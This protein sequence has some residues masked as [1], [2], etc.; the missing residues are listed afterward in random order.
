MMKYMYR[1]ICFIV[2][3]FAKKKYTN[4]LIRLKNYSNKFI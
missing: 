2:L 1:D 3:K 4:K